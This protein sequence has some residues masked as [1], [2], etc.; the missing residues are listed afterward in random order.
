MIYVFMEYEYEILVQNSY[1][2]EI[3][4]TE[5]IA[6]SGGNIEEIGS[7]D[8]SEAA[9]VIDAEDNLVAPGLNDCHRHL[10]RAYS[11]IGSRKPQENAADSYN[12]HQQGTGLRGYNTYGGKFDKFHEGMS[13]EEMKDN[14]VTGIESSVEQGTTGLRTHIIID[15]P[16]KLKNIEA[17]IEAKKETEEIV[18]LQIVPMTIGGVIGSEENE[19]LTRD[20]IEM[21]LEEMDRD[22]VVVGGCDPATRNKKDIREIV[23][24]WFEIAA[25]YDLKLDPHIQDGGT[26]GSYTVKIILEVAREYDLEHKVTLSHAYTFAHLPEESQKGL[27]NEVHDDGHDIVTCYCFTPHEFPVKMMIEEDINLGMG[28]DNTEDY[29]LPHGQTDPLRGA[30]VLIH[31]LHKDYEFD[32]DSKWFQSNE[33]LAGLWELITYN[34]ANVLGI[35][36][37]YGIEVG[38]KADLVVY[39]EPS[40]EWAVARKANAEYV[41]KDGDVVAESGELV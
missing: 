5:D 1:I 2:D 23:E 38:N 26:V 27:A 7:I 39:D 13:V 24:K 32:S 29:V 35:E 8:A 19:K 28:T 17:A 33:G 36:D 18:D 22:D 41:I 10:D 25:E 20:A 9:T 37:E 31:K 11:S 12:S 40:V 14:I 3:E 34:G 21:C 30:N 6:V 15:H 4:D 16:T